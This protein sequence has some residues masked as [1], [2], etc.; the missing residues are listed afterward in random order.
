VPVLNKIDRPEAQVEKVKADLATFL[1]ISEDEVLSISAKTGENC[2]AVLEAVISKIPHPKK[3]YTVSTAP[4]ARITPGVMFA[5]GLI[6]DSYY[7]SH[8]GVIAFVRSFFGSF[9]K[10]SQ[11][12]LVGSG[13]N[14]TASEV[15]Y[16]LPELT[17][18][19][20]ICPGEIGYIVT[21]LKSIKQVRVGD[22]IT[23]A[24]SPAPALSGYRKT[25]P[26][27]FAFIF[28]T[29][30]ADYES[31]VEAMEKL[32]LNDSSLDSSGIYSQ[33][34]GPGLR[35]GFL[36]LLHAEI[37]RE[38][39][40]QEYNLDLVITP[41]QVEFKTED[42]TFMEPIAKATIIVPSQYVNKVMTVSFDF[43]AQLLR[44]L[45]LKLDNQIVMEFEIP[46]SELMAN[47][48]F[49]TLKSISSGYGSL[50]WDF[51][52]YR[53]VEAA[54]LEIL[55]NNKPI[56]E[57]SQIVVKNKAQ[58]TAQK[59]VSKLKKLIPRQQYEVRIQARYQNKIIASSR[60]APFRKDVTAKLYG[61]D[62]SRKDKLLKK[63]KKGK[64]QLKQIGTISLP[65]ETFIKLFRD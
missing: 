63:Q 7:D 47:N 38:R 14:F 61:G 1:G 18:A 24:L 25:K 50:D 29:D 56:D 33:A 4:S 23:T 54:N 45:N 42:K 44:T 58:L 13:Q 35:V 40:E 65:K 39:L 53:P 49:D 59:Y 8:R 19:A 11:L 3:N 30:N 36:G 20:A 5:Q 52:E 17:P 10:G 62:R 41:A 27:V 16:F 37:I 48:F 46:L 15:G 34:L 6:F 2:E 64:G 60:V 26:M 9:A 21:T 32:S 28:P 55:I 12:K 43:R 22:T 51:L 31:L 57:F